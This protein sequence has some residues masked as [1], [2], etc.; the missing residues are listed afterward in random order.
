MCI[1]DSNRRGQRTKR[2]SVRRLQASGTTKFNSLELFPCDQFRVGDSPILS[3]EDD[4]G[5]IIDRL[6]I[7]CGRGSSATP[8]VDGSCREKRIIIVV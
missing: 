7:N 8:A 1:R 6:A 2:R 5:I 3:I 4:L